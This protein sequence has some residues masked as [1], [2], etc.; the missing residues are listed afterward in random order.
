M[1]AGAS[2]TC[3]G[4]FDRIS[5]TEWVDKGLRPAS[6]LLFCSTIDPV[7]TNEAEIEKNVS[8]RSAN[9]KINVP[10]P[11][12]RNRLPYFEATALLDDPN[13]CSSESLYSKHCSG[14]FLLCV[15]V[16]NMVSVTTGETPEGTNKEQTVE[17]W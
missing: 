6:G 16:A 10:R 3:D 11:F 13:G 14:L 5:S 1:G 7:A 17:R 15:T 4:F 2:T 8:G 9:N 12:T